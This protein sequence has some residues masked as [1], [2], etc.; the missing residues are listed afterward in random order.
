M[1][2]ICERPHGSFRAEQEIPVFKRY[3]EVSLILKTAVDHA[4]SQ[5]AQRKPET[6]SGHVIRQF[7]GFGPW[8][9]FLIFFCNLCGGMLFSG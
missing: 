1:R 3:G 7:G 5:S 6:D 8:Q 2:A 9:N 4:K